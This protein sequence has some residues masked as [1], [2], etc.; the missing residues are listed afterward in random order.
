MIQIL[1]PSLPPVYLYKLC[2]CG[3]VLP[4][5]GLPA[6]VV[7]AQLHKTMF[8]FWLFA[9]RNPNRAIFNLDIFGSLFLLMWRKA[10]FQW[11][12]VGKHC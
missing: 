8:E 6:A 4:P 2:F 1:A 10:F 7:G 9:N 11:L 5:V 3:V 12:A